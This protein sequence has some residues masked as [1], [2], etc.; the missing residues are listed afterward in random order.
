M[1]NTKRAKPHTTLS[2]STRIEE[3]I[4]IRQ[5][6]YYRKYLYINMLWIEASGNYC[7]IHL[8]N[9]STIIIIKSISE[10]EKVLPPHIFIR[11]H[12]SY[13]INIH[14][15]DSFTGNILYIGEARLTVSA[16]YRES[17]H[18]HFTILDSSKVFFRQKRRCSVNDTVKSG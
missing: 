9:C 17:V 14:A 2:T 4:F 18:L 7:Y 13:I 12:R 8:A 16:P 5:K 3:G 1:E 11:I 10:L 6:D 15:V